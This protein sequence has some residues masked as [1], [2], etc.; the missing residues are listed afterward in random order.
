M[1]IFGL[2]LDVEACKYSNFGE[3]VAL[4][5]GTCFASAGVE[6]TAIDFGLANLSPSARM[7]GL[8]VRPQKQRLRHLISQ[9]FG[10]GAGVPGRRFVLWGLAY[11]LRPGCVYKPTTA[12]CAQPRASRWRSPTLRRRHVKLGTSLEIDAGNQAGEQR[13]RC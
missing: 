8:Q 3:W 12:S 6:I 9:H 1:D 7:P 13:K 10:G 11:G 5:A 4:D 2:G